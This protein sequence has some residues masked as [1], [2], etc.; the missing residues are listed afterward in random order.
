M[1]QGRFG[2]I[3]SDI[4]QHLLKLSHFYAKSC[5]TLDESSGACAFALA[6]NRWAG[7]ESRAWHRSRPMKSREAERDRRVREREREE[8]KRESQSGRFAKL[9]LKR[10][11]KLFS[12]HYIFARATG[13][14]RAGQRTVFTIACHGQRRIAGLLLTQLVEPGFS[15]SDSTFQPGGTN[16]PTPSQELWCERSKKPQA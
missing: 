7:L 13:L 8:K 3:L 1:I 12:G 9:Q 5:K 14:G 10:R 15:F 2:V 4:V 16:S 6:S 11:G